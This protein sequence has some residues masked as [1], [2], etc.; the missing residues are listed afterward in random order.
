V[1]LRRDKPGVMDVD[2]FAS[3][4]HDDGFRLLTT[5]AA[6]NRGYARTVGELWLNIFNKRVG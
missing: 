3:D 4:N 1:I 5:R 2:A 6:S